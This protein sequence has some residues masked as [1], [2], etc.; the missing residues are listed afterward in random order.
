MVCTNPSGPSSGQRAPPPAFCSE[1]SFTAQ[2]ETLRNAFTM[3]RRTVSATETQAATQEPYAARC[4][5]AVTHIFVYNYQM[6]VWPWG[7]LR[8]LSRWLVPGRWGLRDRAPSLGDSHSYGTEVHVAPRDVEP[9]SHSQGTILEASRA[10]WTSQRA[11]LLEGQS[12]ERVRPL[13]APQIPPTS[14]RCH[15]A[16]G[17]GRV[18][19]RLLNR[20]GAAFTRE[21]HPPGLPG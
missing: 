7:T 16:V 13:A 1:P 18:A 4:F 14:A 11:C 21:Q 17:V 5:V 19:S 15:S 12:A 10:P 2:L 3:G 9:L 20:A 6:R 8:F